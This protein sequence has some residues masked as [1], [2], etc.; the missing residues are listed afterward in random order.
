M[1]PVDHPGHPAPAKYFADVLARSLC[2]E[3]RARAWCEETSAYAPIKQKRCPV[4]LPEVMPIHCAAALESSEA[5]KGAFADKNFRGGT[6]LPQEIEI[7]LL[8]REDGELCVVVG[9]SADPPAS[10][11]QALDAEDGKGT[12]TTTTAA[13]AAAGST[14]PGAQNNA[15]ASEG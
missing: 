4:S 12:T 1:I 15:S 5:T 13:A 2:R 8:E 11:V 6:W 9:E 14:T 3:T 7:S 10:W